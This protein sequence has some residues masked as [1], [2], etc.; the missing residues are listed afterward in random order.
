MVK[1]VLLSFLVS[2]PLFVCGQAKE[3]YLPRD[4]ENAIINKTRTL[5]GLPGEKYF[6]NFT[7]YNIDVEFF[8]KT[9]IVKG[10]G[11]ILYHNNSPYR[12]RYIV[13]RLSQ[14]VLQSGAVRGR[15]VDPEDLSNGVLLKKIIIN[16][17]K[18][19]GKNPVYSTQTNV[20][21]PMSLNSGETAEID[22][23]W[24]FILPQRTHIRYGCYDQEACF[25]AYW[26]P[27]VSVFDDINGWDLSD[28]TGVAEFYNSYG[29]YK[30]NIKVPENYIVWASGELSNADEV[31]MPEY[32]NRY[33]K[34][35]TTDE[36][37]HI[38]DETDLSRR[39]AFTKKKS[40]IWKFNADKINDFAFGTSKSYR[41]DATSIEITN[42]EGS[43]S[44][45]LIESAFNKN[46][47]N[48]REVAEIA[49]WSVKDFSEDMPGIPY[50]YPK[51]TVF[52]GSGGMEFP[53]IVNDGERN[54]VQTLFVTTHEIG[55]TYFPFM[56]GTNQKRHGWIDEGLITMIAQEQHNKRDTTYSFRNFY[57]DQ[58]PVV[59]GTQADVPPFVNS[60]YI[61]NEIFQTHDYMR[62]SM[63][64]W[65]L[66]DILGNDVFRNC[67]Q[68]FINTWEGK[69]PTPWDMFNL[70]EKTSERKLGWFFQPWFGEF[71]YPDIML[72]KIVSTEG[73]KQIQITNKGGMPFP[74]KL[75]F[76]FSDGEEIK[77]EIPADTWEN[78]SEHFVNVP[79][80]Q[81]FQAARLITDGYPDVNL[82]NNYIEN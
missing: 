35:K 10:S 21:Y 33:N 14:N 8:P 70:F 56:V 2:I 67:L 40:N 11:T 73:A 76:I 13:L 28:Y 53:M 65:V 34:A 75:V 71:A 26:F 72:S 1:T 77:I 42:K 47:V 17:T 68:A 74:A 31:L 50:P 16:G 3:V 39:P 20:V 5:T 78:S 29:N 54:P 37:I 60:L 27:Q 69:H 32:L 45:I 80:Y 12:L 19:D 41:W 48:F 82:E 22:M 15:S 59:A 7:D 55:H 44:R 63:A 24:E 9:R 49:A 30:V 43:T 36:I 79:N 52:N 58:Y 51:L 66:K 46:S 18:Y 6:Q 62:P 57:L 4:I 61:S 38:I 64:F 23:E 25:V 81:N